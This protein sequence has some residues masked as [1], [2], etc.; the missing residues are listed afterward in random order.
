MC[1]AGVLWSQMQP[2]LPTEDPGGD[3]HPGWTVPLPVPG[4]GSWL[5]QERGPV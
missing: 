5:R 2:V 4:S 3:C 1:A